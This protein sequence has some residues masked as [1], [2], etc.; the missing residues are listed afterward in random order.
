MTPRLVVPDA[1]LAATLATLGWAAGVS[2]PRRSAHQRASAKGARVERLARLMFEAM[3]CRVETAPKVV[4]WI[5]K[6]DA[7]PG[8]CAACARPFAERIPRSMRH[9]FFN[10]WDLVVVEASGLVRFVQ[11]TEPTNLSAHRKKILASAWPPRD[12]DLLLTYAGRSRFRVYHGPAFDVE[13]GEL[14][15]PP[16]S[17]G[18]ARTKGTP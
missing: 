8:A 9:D 11:I 1:A 17:R 13:S 3:G 7:R 16:Q 6:K 10:V 12:D 2:A 15:V 4:V 18:A 5:P 14:R